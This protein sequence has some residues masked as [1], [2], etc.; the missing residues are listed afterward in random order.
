MGEARR[1]LRLALEALAQG[2]VTSGFRGDGL[3]RDVPSQGVVVALVD[4]ARR[5]LADLLQDPVFSDL[6]Q[7]SPPSAAL[8]EGAAGLGLS[9]SGS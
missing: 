5:S 9:D 1:R 4:S 3:D 2:I 8:R 7:A 6:L